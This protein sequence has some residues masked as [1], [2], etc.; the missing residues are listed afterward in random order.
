MIRTN[1]TLGSP[2]PQNNSGA[3]G[4]VDYVQMG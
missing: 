1:E 3:M 4:L 2:K